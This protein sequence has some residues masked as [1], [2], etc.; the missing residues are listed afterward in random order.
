MGARLPLLGGGGTP[1]PLERIDLLLRAF[2]QV[3]AKLPAAR[4]LICG[5]TFTRDRYNLE[6]QRLADELNLGRKAIFAGVRS[7]IPEILAEANVFALPTEQDACPLV[8][9]EAM[10]ASLPAVA[11]TSG[12]VPEMV[13]HGETGL[14]SPPGDLEGLVNNLLALLQDSATAERMGEAGK[15]RVFAEFAHQQAGPKWTRNLEKMLGRASPSGLMG[16]ERAR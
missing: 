15:R 6:L 9:M 7:D 14:L 5:G 13:S 2:A 8:F 3:S 10:A 12:G 1:R 4:L 16:E 11:V